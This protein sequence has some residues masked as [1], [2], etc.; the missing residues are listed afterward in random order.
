[1]CGASE[2]ATWHWAPGKPDPSRPSCDFRQDSPWSRGEKAS[3]P[4]GRGE[5]LP[6]TLEGGVGCWEERN[7]TQDSA[8]RGVEG[9]LPLVEL[10][11]LDGDHGA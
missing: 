9:V 6:R 2:Q 11:L 10:E 8:L 4:L 1:M 5:M 3:P 7:V